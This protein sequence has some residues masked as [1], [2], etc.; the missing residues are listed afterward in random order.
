MRALKIK[1]CVQFYLLGIIAGMITIAGSIFVAAGYGGI[2]LCVG[3]SVLCILGLYLATRKPKE[4]E[5][6]TVF[7][8][9]NYK[10]GPGFGF[11]Q[12]VTSALWPVTAAEIDTL[13]DKARKASGAEEVVLVNIVPLCDGKG[14]RDDG[15]RS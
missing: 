3:G 4:P 7:V 12:Y 15:T 13:L 11:G 8:A 2:P 10:K 1:R 6:R 14:G 5:R 9:Y